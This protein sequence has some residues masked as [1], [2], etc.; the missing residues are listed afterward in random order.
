MTYI[1]TLNLRSFNNI[2]LSSF[3]YWVPFLLSLVCRQWT[4]LFCFPFFSLFDYKGLFKFNILK[5][6]LHSILLLH[7][8]E[9]MVV[10]RLKQKCHVSGVPWLI[11]TGS[12][13]DDWIYWCL[14]L[15]SLL[16]TINYNNSQSIYCWG[17]APFRIGERL[18]SLLVFLLLWL[19]WFWLTGRSLIQLP[20]SAG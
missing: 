11:I 20:L 6:I 5:S 7:C 12:V 2:L 9:F 8:H 17:L 16:I 10:T 3:G 19:T 13:L 1:R 15:Q 14:L 4:D 18:Y